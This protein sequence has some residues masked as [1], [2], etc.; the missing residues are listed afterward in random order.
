MPEAEIKDQKLQKIVYETKGAEYDLVAAETIPHPDGY[1]KDLYLMG[2]T[3]AHVITDEQGKA[4]L[5]DLPLGRY[6]IRETKAPSGYTRK[7]KDAKRNTELLWKDSADLEI[8][9]TETF[10]N[11]R[12]KID[13]GQEPDGPEVSP[14]VPEEPGTIIGEEWKGNVWT[15]RKKTGRK[16]QNSHF[17]R[18]KI[19]RTQTEVL[20]C[21]QERR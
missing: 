2:T 1:S 10:F 6:E 19:L 20:C 3:I 17:M 4:V 5:S 15:E 9:A 16:E 12:Q 14:T 7:Q 13:I 21:R 11:E 18:K 8:T